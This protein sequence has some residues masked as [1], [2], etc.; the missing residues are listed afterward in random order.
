MPK[1]KSLAG[2]I[3]TFWQ[4]FKEDFD[5]MDHKLLRIAISVGTFIIMALFWL[6]FFGST[7]PFG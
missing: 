5:A 7:T 2:F 3:G 4:M 1:V 6:Y